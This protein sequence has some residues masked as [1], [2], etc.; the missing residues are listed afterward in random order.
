MCEDALHH[1]AAAIEWYEKFLAHVPEKLA[2]QGEEIKKREAELKALPGKVHVHDTTPPGADA[3]G[4]RQA[5][6][7]G[8][9]PRSMSSSPPGR[10]R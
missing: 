5:P 7:N 6:G 8:H 4:R 10:T 3:H 9:R 1:P 2:D